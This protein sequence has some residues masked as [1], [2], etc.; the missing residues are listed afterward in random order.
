MATLIYS[1]R[2]SEDG[3]WLLDYGSL[4]ELDKVLSEE[5]NRLEMPEELWIEE[6]AGQ[7]MKRNAWRKVGAEQEEGLFKEALETARRDARARAERGIVLHLPGGHKLAV[8]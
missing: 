4:I 8:A 5:W 1:T 3:P 6:H 7:E 2:F